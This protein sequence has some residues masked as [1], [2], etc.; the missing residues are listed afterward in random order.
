MTAMSGLNTFE[1]VTAEP[2]RRQRACRTTGALG[3]RR[4]LRNG[5]RCER[6][7]LAVAQAER[8]AEE[9]P[10]QTRAWFP[11]RSDGR[12]TAV[13]VHRNLC[14]ADRSPAAAPAD[15][16]ARRR[17]TA[18]SANAP[19]IT[20]AH[21][22]R[23]ALMKCLPVGGPSACRGLPIEKDALSEIGG[24][25]AASRADDEKSV[26]AETVNGDGAP[27]VGERATRQG[28][29]WVWGLEPSCVEVHERAVLRRLQLALEVVML[30]RRCDQE[31][32]IQRH[33]DKRQ[34]PRETTAPSS[35][36][37]HRLYALNRPSSSAPHDNLEACGHA[38]QVGLPACWETRRQCPGCPA[39]GVLHV[40][41]DSRPSWWIRNSAPP[42]N[43]K[44]AWRVS[45]VL[46]RI[47]ERGRFLVAIVIRSRQ[48][49]TAA[50]AEDSAGGSD[51]R[52]SLRTA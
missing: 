24:W 35:N 1:P 31:Q 42:F 3:A 19:A 6:P 52:R 33:P 20:E 38:A 10:Q 13:S 18:H 39:R 16:P 49:R 8:L 50:R 5:R 22:N 37:L 32:G 40:D 26:F 17:S 30:E 44:P 15:S 4:H 46:T 12:R 43:T 9:F 25:R 34:A 41:S 48:R 2:V 23:L 29:S 51:S 21:T 36:H 11:G 47:G 14:A 45:S 28:S 7:P 27:G